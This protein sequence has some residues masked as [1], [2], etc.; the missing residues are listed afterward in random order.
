ML[1]L[2]NPNDAQLASLSI[3]RNSRWRQR[4]PPFHG[5]RMVCS[6]LVCLFN[7]VYIFLNKIIKQWTISWF[8]PN[9]IFWYLTNQ[10]VI[11]LKMLQNCTDMDENNNKLHCWRYWVYG[12][13]SMPGLTAITQLL[14]RLISLHVG[15][16]FYQFSVQLRFV[17]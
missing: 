12:L 15:W 16:L 11:F 1:L 17:L 9:V 5:F 10:T 4:R 13:K 2:K 3:M 6:I 14:T 7:K 8:S